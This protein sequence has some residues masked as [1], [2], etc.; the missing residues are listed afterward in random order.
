[1]QRLAGVVRQRDHGQHLVHAVGAQPA[2]QLVV[3]Q[4][5]RRP[6]PAPPRTGRPRPRGCGRTPAAGGTSRSR[7]SR[8]RLGRSR[9]RAGGRPARCWPAAPPS[10]TAAAVEVEGRDRGA[11]LLVVDGRDSRE[12]GRICAAHRHGLH[13]DVPMIEPASSPASSRTPRTGPGS[14]ASP[15]PSAASSPPTSTASDLGRLLRDDADRLGRGARPAGGD[16]AARRAHLVAAGVRLPR[17]RR[18]PHLRRA[19]GPD[20]RAGR[21]DLRQLGPGRD[22]RR[23]AL[24]PPGPGRGRARAGRRRPRRSPRGTTR[25]STR[26]RRP[27]RG[28]ALRSNGSE[29]TVDSTRPLPPARRAAPQPRRPRAAP[30]APPWRR[31]TADAEA[32]SEASWAMLNDEVRAELDWLAGAVGAGGV[33]A[34]D[35]QR[36]RPG[37]GRSSRSAGCACGV[38]TSRRRSSS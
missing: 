24:R 35:R 33:G 29:F 22:G 7:R 1:M 4:P 38:P 27:G 5:A 10:R 16:R 6:A 28:A 32:Y 25:S 13:D 9:R 31:T 12:V 21:A 3:Q 18:A 36:R 15:A 34:R 19:A 20:A 26:P 23:G 30:R 17:P 8:R 2:E 37:R 14:S 11:H